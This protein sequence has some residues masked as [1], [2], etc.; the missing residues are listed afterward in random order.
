MKLFGFFCCVVQFG[1]TLVL[2]P[3]EEDVH[4]LCDR[5]PAERTAALLDVSALRQDVGAAPA[6]TKVTAGKQQHRLTQ[7]LT[8]DTLLPLLLLLQQAE[9]LAVSRRA[10]VLRSRARRGRT[11]PAAVGARRLAVL[12]SV[13]LQSVWRAQL[14]GGRRVGLS[15][16]N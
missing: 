7:V 15:G 1:V 3:S 4:G 14:I 12:L 13:E 9:Q 6:E 16:E 5:L 2:K 10:A 11:S 8:D